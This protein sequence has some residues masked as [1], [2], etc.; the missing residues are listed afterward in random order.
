[1]SAAQTRVLALPIIWTLSIAIK[2]EVHFFLMR[3]PWPEGNEQTTDILSPTEAEEDRVSPVDCGVRG[4]SSLGDAE[5]SPTGTQHVNRCRYTSDARPCTRRHIKKIKGA[6]RKLA[7]QNPK[8]TSSARFIILSKFHVPSRASRALSASPFPPVGFISEAADTADI[9]LCIRC[10]N[11]LFP[12][13]APGR[14][15]VRLAVITVSMHAAVVYLMAKTRDTRSVTH[16]R[17]FAR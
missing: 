5:L 6:A 10:Y 12:R 3:L 13:P 4:N 9:W 7:D 16:T 2:T 15:V 11:N 8:S 14:S 17:P 1:M